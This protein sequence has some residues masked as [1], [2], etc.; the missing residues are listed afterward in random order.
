MRVFLDEIYG[1][2]SLK[3]LVRNEFISFMGTFR[4]YDYIVLLAFE[5]Q[6]DKQLEFKHAN[7][8]R[9]TWK[10]EDDIGLRVANSMSGISEGMTSKVFCQR[11]YE[12]K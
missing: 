12:N 2:V 8:E 9:R 1:E 6:L 11:Y 10:P 5:V 4:V 3:F 7:M